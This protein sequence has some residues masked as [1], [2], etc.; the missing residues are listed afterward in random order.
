[1][2]DRP[3]EAEAVLRTVKL[4]MRSFIQQ[5]SPLRAFLQTTSEVPSTSVLSY[6]VLGYQDGPCPKDDQTIIY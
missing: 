1:M 2:F 5:A 6:I 4:E 3:G